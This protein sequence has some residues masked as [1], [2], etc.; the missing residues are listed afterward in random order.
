M[1]AALVVER[2]ISTFTAEELPRGSAGDSICFMQVSLQYLFK[3]RR[4][5]LASLI[6]A[7]SALSWYFFHLRDSLQPLPPPVIVSTLGSGVPARMDS[8]V[9]DYSPD[10]QISAAGADPREPEDPWREPS[11]RFAFTYTGRQLA[12]QLATGNYWGYLYVTVN[13]APANR[14]AHIAGNRNSQGEIAGYKPLLAPEWQTPAGPTPR[15][16]IVHEAAGEGPHQVEVEVWRSWGQNPVRAVAVDALSAPAPPLW[17]AVAL[18]LL[19]LFCGVLLAGQPLLSF[20]WKSVNQIRKVS[21]RASDPLLLGLTGTALLLVGGGVLWRSWLITSAGLVLLALVGVQRPLFWIGALLFG[22]PFYL[23]PLPILPGR[24]LNLIEIGVWGGLL[25]LA[26]HVGF[27]HR[28]QF[29]PSGSAGDRRRLLSQVANPGLL[30]SALIALALV[31]VFAAEQR[32]VALRE[33]RTVFLAAGGFALLLS[34]TLSLEGR[35][36]AQRTLVTFWLMGGT[37]VALIA[38]W[39]YASGRML[40]EAEGVN[41]ARAFYGSPNNLA[42]YLERTVAVAL[43]LIILTPWR[44]NKHHSER[45]RR[46]PPASG[47]T[48]LDPS[49]SAPF[50]WLLGLPQ[51]AA[52]LLTFSK[53]ALLLALPA[54]LIVLGIGGYFL[55]RRGGESMRPLW[56]LAAVVTIILVGMSPFLGAERFRLLLDFSSESTGGLRLNL[57]RS[58]WAMALDH[59]WLGV[60]PDNFLYIYRNSY[61]L[62]AAWQDPDLNHPHNIV[63]DLWTRVGFFG[64]ISAA[65]WLLAGIKQ[66]GQKLKNSQQ[67]VLSLGCLAAIAGA[68]AHGLIDASYALPDL[69]LVWVLLLGLIGENIES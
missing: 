7:A 10:W 56:A 15:W 39:Q 41:R 40:I 57:W 30:L 52:L 24:E 67:A 69:I 16:I 34:G 26:A 64:F 35:S 21:W 14:L 43:A 32:A 1:R 6:F 18:A 58:S 49:G 66:M 47:S 8:P 17:P 42:L 29:E 2:P 9:F 65:A 50:W 33:W 55:L 3:K 60:G 54:S 46:N 5:L 51:L 62:P 28:H 36:Q 23:H 48:P 13:N 44:R 45:D 11:G 63:L 68:L 12:M 25:L 22:L 53:G 27:Y 37:V 31:A 20:F 59:M 61:I 38:L 19:A 4:L